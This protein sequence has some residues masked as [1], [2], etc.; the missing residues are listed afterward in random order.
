[1]RGPRIHGRPRKRQTFSTSSRA[2]QSIR[3]GRHGRWQT[4]VSLQTFSTEALQ[5][6][7][8]AEQGLRALKS[9]MDDCGRM[10]H[11]MLQWIT[12]C[13][14]PWKIDRAFGDMQHDSASGPRLATYARYNV[15][16]EQS[17]LK[18]EV[19]IECGQ[20]KLAKI[21]ELDNPAQMEELAAI[22]AVAAK[23]QINSSHFDGFDIRA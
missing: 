14:T 4:E 22:G 9:L 23:S 7:V 13:V 8:A 2:C 12:H 5:N 18:T 19:K 16:L 3:I 15:L 1:M 6:M 11:A 20:E 17:W 21:A 10:N